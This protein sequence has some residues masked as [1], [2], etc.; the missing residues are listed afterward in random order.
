MATG[1]GLMSKQRPKKAH[2][3]EGKQGVAGEVDDLRSDL[4]TEL[5]PMA[6]LAVEEFTDPI[7][8]DPNGIKTSIASVAAVVTYSG[9]DLD[10]VLGGGPFSPPRNVTV[11]TAGVTPADAPATLTVTGTDINGTVIT[12]DI[13]V[14]QTATIAV[15]TKAFATV[16]SLA[17][18]AGD[19]TAALLEFG[20]GDVFG[21]AHPLVS[22]AGAAGVITEIEAG[23]VVTTG[24][25]VDAAT[26]APNGT[27]EPA[28]VPDATNDYALYYEYDPTA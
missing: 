27:Y 6:A 18:T 25:F 15:G 2:L 26:S 7:A 9:A 13:S 17:L 28:T 23:S 5:G 1:S 11:S 22:R 3:V 8:A 20:I 10:G 14:A 19:G 21:L 24:T 4:V 16:T 12:E